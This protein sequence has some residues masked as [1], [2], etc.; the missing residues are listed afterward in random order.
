MKR[1]L[2]V[3][4]AVAMTSGASH[5]ATVAGHVNFLTKRGQRPV[6]QETVVWL[7]PAAGM[8]L[9]VRPPQNLQITT[10]GKMLLPHVLVI[11]AGSAV[12]FPNEDPISHNLFSLTPGN[13]FDLGLYRTG[14]GKSHTF[15]SPGVV[16][17]YCNVHSN[18]S[19][20]V[21]VMR[22]PYYALA[23]ANGTFALADVAPGRYDLVAWNELGG[24]SPKTAIDVPAAG[25]ANLALAID[26]R[27]YHPL[28]HLNKEG[29][30][31]TTPRARDY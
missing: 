28:G 31:Y 25:V 5:A 4:T 15:A 7:E 2:L 9:P 6:V 29:K 22:T 10:R 27:N 21:H 24:Y 14:P 13:Q 12:A 17:V 1:L 23:A 16:N 11:P 18:M 26:S 30:A 8:K 19:A 3:V 20:V